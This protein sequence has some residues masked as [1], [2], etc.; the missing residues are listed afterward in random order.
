MMLL[1]A[2]CHVG[3]GAGA[4]RYQPGCS[5]PVGAAGD[6]IFGT[7]RRLFGHFVNFV[8]IWLVSDRRRS[9][10]WCFRGLSI[11]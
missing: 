6:G 10:F 1:I 3:V 2:A 7:E 8:D 4:R 5:G 9:R 11:I